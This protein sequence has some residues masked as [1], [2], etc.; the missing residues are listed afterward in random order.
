L[1]KEYLLSP[2]QLWTNGYPRWVE[3]ES[4]TT[5][6]AMDEEEEGKEEAEEFVR[7]TN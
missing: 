4:V 7:K 3:I 6:T 1:A 2:E 5:S